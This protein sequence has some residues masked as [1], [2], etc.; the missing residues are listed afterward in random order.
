MMPSVLKK[1]RTSEGTRAWNLLMF[2][3]IVYS[4]E[5]LIAENRIVSHIGHSVPTV[6]AQ[7]Y[8]STMI[9]IS[10]KVINA[11]SDGVQKRFARAHSGMVHAHS[12]P[13]SAIIS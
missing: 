7:V 12:C 6:G 9:A 8:T 11:S 1:Q 13:Q 10:N 2:E 3:N 5:Q 4:S